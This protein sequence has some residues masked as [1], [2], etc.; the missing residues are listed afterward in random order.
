VE[1]LLDFK[2]EAKTDPRSSEDTQGEKKQGKEKKNEKGK[3][4]TSKGSKDNAKKT[5]ILKEKKSIS[6]WICAKRTI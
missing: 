1:K 3:E 6:C 4:N 2:C 5:V